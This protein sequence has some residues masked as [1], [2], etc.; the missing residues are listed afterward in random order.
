MTTDAETFIRKFLIHDYLEAIED[1]HFNN[2]FSFSP[3]GQNL[4]WVLKEKNI[5]SG[6]AYRDLEGMPEAPSGYI[7]SY[8]WF[9]RYHIFIKLLNVLRK[10]S[11]EFIPSPPGAPTQR[12]EQ[13]F[14]L[15]AFYILF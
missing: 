3:H 11:E 13:I 15:N 10:D 1:F 8:T 2:K 9:Y 4:C 14:R 6:F 5:P 12:G 7:E